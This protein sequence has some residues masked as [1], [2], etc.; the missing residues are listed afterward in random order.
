MATNRED[1][2]KLLEQ[3]PDDQLGAIARMVR[4]KLGQS[5]VSSRSVM[6]FAGIWSDLTDDELDA[7]L[8][9]YRSREDWPERAVSG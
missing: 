9:P 7:V 4:R 6:D 8:G 5:K 2:L 1:L 3:L